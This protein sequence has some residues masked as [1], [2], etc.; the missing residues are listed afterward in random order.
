MG[1]FIDARQPVRPR[2]VVADDAPPE[3]VVGVV[4]IDRVERG[5]DVTNGLAEA[6]AARHRPVAAHALVD[7]D[8]RAVEGGVHS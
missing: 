1:Q 7:G 5:V 8:I 6:G 4:E 3:C 2:H